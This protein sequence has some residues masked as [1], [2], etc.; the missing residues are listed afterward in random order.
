MSRLSREQKRELERAE[1]RESGSG[2]LPIDV[3]VPASGDNASV[4]GMPVV[5]LPGGTLQ[6]TVLDYLHRIALATGH[7]VL[8]TVH[9]ERIGY[10]V[11]LRIGVDGSSCLVD[12]AARVGQPRP[13][14]AFGVGEPVAAFRVEE[15]PSAPRA[16]P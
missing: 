11:L 16:A 13:E 6:D 8:A 5:A 14:A 1:C 10:A 12:E 9:D 7:P 2:R 3:R 4:G 15:P